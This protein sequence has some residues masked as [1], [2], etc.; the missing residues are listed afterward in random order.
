[1]QKKDKYIIALI[2]V[3]YLIFR[4]M[5]TKAAPTMTNKFTFSKFKK[6]GVADKLK[7]LVPSLIK[8]GFNT[9]HKL[10]LGISQLL[11][12]TGQFKSGS[13]YETN[14]NYSGIKYICKD[15]Q[16]NATRGSDVPPGEKKPPANRCGNFYAKFKDND[17]WAVDYFRILNLVRRGNDIGKPIE[18]VDVNDFNSRLVKNGYYDANK[19][20]AKE[21]YLKNLN[22]FYNNIN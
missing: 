7:L 5:G 4:S 9:D 13:I 1:M 8:A 20:G 22:W 11:L 10:K 19:P 12:E 2:G 21:S 6:P 18:A 15:F 14:N 16:K 17:A 3:V